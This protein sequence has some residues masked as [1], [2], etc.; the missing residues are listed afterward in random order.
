MQTKTAIASASGLVML[1]AAST[2]AL[3]MT[4]PDA[5]PSAQPAVVESVEEAETYEETETYQEAEEYEE[6]ETYEEAEDDDD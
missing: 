4:A 3:L 6:A 2:G 1:V 5:A